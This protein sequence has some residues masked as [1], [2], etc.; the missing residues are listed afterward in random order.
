M[1]LNC[2]DFFLFLLKYTMTN[3]ARQAI[4]NKLSR[5][6]YYGPAEIK[7]SVFL[8]IAALYSVSEEDALKVDKHASEV[9]S[10]QATWNTNLFREIT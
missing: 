2:L 8:T 7:D 5:I 10:E 6:G 9:L 3:E 1:F 4:I